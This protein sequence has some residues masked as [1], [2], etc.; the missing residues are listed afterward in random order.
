MRYI[1]ALFTATFKCKV[2][3]FTATFSGK[4]TFFTATF[5]FLASQRDDGRVVVDDRLV[6]GADVVEVLQ[7][8]AQ[9]QFEGAV[10]AQMQSGFGQWP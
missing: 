6:A 7:D 5:C 4:I 3:F 2:T 10:D 9:H 8:A 1:F